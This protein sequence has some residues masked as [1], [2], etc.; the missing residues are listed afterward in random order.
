MY[1][2]TRVESGNERASHMQKNGLPPVYFY[3]PVD[4]W[5]EE[6]IPTSVESRPDLFFLKTAYNWTLQTYL[7]LRKIDFP[8]ELTSVL[9]REGIVLAFR[10]SMLFDEKPNSKTLFVCIMGDA[11][12]HPYAQL[13][14]VQNPRQTQTVTQ[15]FFI[16]HWPQPGLIPRDSSRGNIFKNIAYFG[17]PT[18]LAEQ[19]KSESW[20][21][22]LRSLGLNWMIIGPEAEARNDY[23]AIDA[24]IAIRS[25]DN[26]LHINKPA[27]KLYNAWRAG[28]P[29]ILGR[30]SAFQAERKSSLD[31]LEAG[32]FDA[33]IANLNELKCNSDLRQAMIENG[34]ARAQELRPTELTNTWRDFII[35]K[36]VPTYNRWCA[37][38]ELKRRTFFLKRYLALKKSGLKHRVRMAASAG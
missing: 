6:G 1:D 14:I 31:Y 26:N 37:T 10:G 25:F 20:A 5:P 17:C 33:L 2:F 12:P 4:E 24:I 11:G 38:S 13:H 35:D 32:T 19:L 8:C 28:T 9:P 27:S 21:E 22:R 15:G 7:Q 36:G 18:N 23:G 34:K 3:L 16:P 29:A 30:E